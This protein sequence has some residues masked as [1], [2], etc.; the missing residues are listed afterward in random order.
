MSIK[1]IFKSSI[2]HIR[3]VFKDGKVANFLNHVYMTDVPSEISELR[4]EIGEEGFGK[5]K[6][7]HIYIDSNEKEFDANAPT[8]LELIKQQARK[9]ALEELRAEQAAAAGNFGGNANRPVLGGIGNSTNS[10]TSGSTALGAAP[11][12]DHDAQKVPAALSTST[13]VAEDGVV[14]PAATVPVTP[15][16]NPTLASAPVAQAKSDIEQPVLTAKPGTGITTTATL[17]PSITKKV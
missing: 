11:F 8:A 10:G 14:V 1:Q 2:P 7:P 17:N 12:V 13:K 9:E 15:T 6:H 16:S 3:L 4:A 5:S